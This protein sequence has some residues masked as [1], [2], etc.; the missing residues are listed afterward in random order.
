MQI[1]GRG[2]VVAFSLSLALVPARAQAQMGSSPGTSEATS[3]TDDTPTDAPQRPRFNGL[4]RG[5]STANDDE[6]SLVF[7]ASAYASYIQGLQN[8][9]DAATAAS[10][11][12]V[13]LLGGGAS[14][15]YSRSWDDAFIGLNAAGSLAKRRV[16]VDNSDWIDR[17]NLDAHG[18][19]SHDV[20]R[21]TRLEMTGSSFYSPYRQFGLLEAVRGEDRYSFVADIGHGNPPCLGF[22]RS[23]RQG[24]R[25]FR[26]L[27]RACGPQ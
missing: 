3:G 17:W 13:R 5:A 14:L 10:D 11:K 15:R 1:S 6:Q 27:E 7:S 18:G 24:G 21:R 20:G 22:G 16:D 8:E 2:F 9:T 19:F 25:M 12:W 23:T 26:R 4:F